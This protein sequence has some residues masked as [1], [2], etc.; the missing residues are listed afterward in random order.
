MNDVEA[1]YEDLD[2]TPESGINQIFIDL[3][4]YCYSA[5]YGCG[6]DNMK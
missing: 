6:L 1:D 5:S 4:L 3:H 2:T